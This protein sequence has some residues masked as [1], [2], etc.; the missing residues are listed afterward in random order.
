M[1]PLPSPA[2]DT[3]PPA[4]SPELVAALEHGLSLHNLLQEEFE[5]LRVQDLQAFEALQEPKLDIFKILTQLTGAGEE[6][7]VLDEPQWDTFKNLI[8]DCRDM[9]RRNEVL[10]SRKLDAIRGTL[11]TLRGTSDPAASVDVYDRLGRMSRR[12]GGRG[13]EDA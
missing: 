10:I 9:H 8:N 1:M 5:A 6:N 7:K 2:A 12:R 4:T 3:L 11:N 13:Y